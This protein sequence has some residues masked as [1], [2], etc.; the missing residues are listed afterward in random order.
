VSTFSLLQITLDHSIERDSFL[1][2]ATGSV[3]RVDLDQVYRDLYGIVISNLSREDAVKLQVELKNRNFPTELVADREIP[4]LPRD[5]QMQR[6]EVEGDW[7]RFTD[8]MGRESLRSLSDLVFISGGLMTDSKLRPD[9]KMIPRSSSRD[10]SPKIERNYRAEE[11]AEFRIEFFFLSD[12]YRLK[13]S[14]TET[15]TIFYQKQPLRLQRRGP[16][17]E[18]V[19]DLR[20]LVPHDRLSVGLLRPEKAYPSAKA[21]LE[22][23]RWHFYQLRKTG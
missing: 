1:D 13:L 16:V 21:Y 4:V 15:S 23:I 11:H 10:R 18:A 8:A 6:L 9:D 14:L 12:P 19:A 7:L 17:Y 22:E 3:A 20:S 2:A 5:F